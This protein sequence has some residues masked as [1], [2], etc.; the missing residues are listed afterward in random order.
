M[1]SVLNIVLDLLFIVVFDW[2]IEGAA[3]ATVVAQGI[4]MFV[5]LCYVNE[6]HPILSIKRKDLLFDKEVFRQS[7]RIGLPTSVQQCAIALGLMTLL[8]IVNQFGT[9]TLT[10]YGA[11]G[12]I[13]TLITQ[14]ILTLSGALST[15]CGQNVGAGKMA[16]CSRGCTLFD[17]EYNTAFGIVMFAAVYFAG[18]YM[19]MIFTNDKDVVEIG[20]SY[21]TITGFF[22][23]IHGALNVFNGALRGAG[24]NSLH[25]DCEPSVFV[26]CENS[27]GLLVQ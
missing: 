2:G 22:F 4:G 8:G 1:S 17:D 9:N 5:A 11:A 15:F 27:S 7:L 20:H 12:K 25:H 21:L 14:A 13:D 16:V 3:R 23:C 18:D 19:M 6:K 26:A 24:D 10:A